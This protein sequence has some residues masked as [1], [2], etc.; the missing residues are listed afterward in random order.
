MTPT[1]TPSMRRKADDDVARPAGMHF[2]QL[3][4]VDD[5]A[6]DGVHVHRL[7]RVVS[8]IK[9]MHAPRPA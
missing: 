5:A 7:R 8:G 2:Q 4:V 1:T 6:D 9:C 3:A